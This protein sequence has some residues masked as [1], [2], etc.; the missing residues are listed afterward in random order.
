M[1]YRTEIIN[2]GFKYIVHIY[3]YK[4]KLGLYPSHEYL[5]IKEEFISLIDVYKY[6]ADYLNELNNTKIEHFDKDFNKITYDKF[7]ENCLYSDVLK[8]DFHPED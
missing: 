3:H 6:I 7:V 4:Y 1:Y 2:N 8:K 5:K